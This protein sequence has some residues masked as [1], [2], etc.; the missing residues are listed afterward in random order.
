MLMAVTRQVSRSIGDCELTFLSRTSIDVERARRQHEQ[1][2]VAL[3]RLGLAL[4]SLPEAPDLPDSVFVED[5]ALVLDECAILMRCAAASRAPEIE[6]MAG[7]LGPYRQLLRLEPPA[8]MDGGDILRIDRSVFVG[9]SQRTDPAAV[10]QLRS[11]LGPFGYEVQAVPVT[12]CLHLK[13]A[14]TKVADSTLLINPG[15]VSSQAFG[16]VKT[17]ET[18]AS[19]PYAANA[20]LVAGS[21]IYSTEFPKTRTRL[22]AAG[23]QTVPVEADEL[24]KA[25]GAVTCC[26]L[27]FST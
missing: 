2:E 23:I 27:I 14:V 19:E 13:S 5:A 22:A 15:W 7:V 18:D 17:I 20:L 12:E 24:A 11:L 6:L 26:S 1:Y 10:E 16:D 9:L 25:E 8:H 3:K 21:V 4:L